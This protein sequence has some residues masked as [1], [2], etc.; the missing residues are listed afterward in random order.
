ME[1]KVAVVVVVVVA[2]RRKRRS[3]VQG[4]LLPG[5]VRQLPVKGGAPGNGV[6]LVLLE[7]LLA[8]QAVG[9][10]RG[11]APGQGLA[12]GAR[13]AVPRGVPPEGRLVLAGR[14]LA[15]H[16]VLHHGDAVELG[17]APG[18]RQGG[19]KRGRQGE[20]VKGSG[21]TQAVNM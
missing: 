9:P 18:G 12:R 19:G 6:G 1:V 5:P 4:R 8:L 15:V 2:A 21:N 17:A 14:A 7:D 3:G 13:H 16:L 10:L 11:G 20:K